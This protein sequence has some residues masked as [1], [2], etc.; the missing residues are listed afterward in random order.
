MEK[1]EKS[2]R[3]V[4]C[5]GEDTDMI[6]ACLRESA[7]AQHLDIAD[8]LERDAL[9]TMLGRYGN[10]TEERKTNIRNRVLRCKG[11]QNDY[12]A[13]LDRKAE[14]ALESGASGIAEYAELVRGYDILKLAGLL[15]KLKK[16]E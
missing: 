5:L 12:L 14:N 1:W 7:L 3:K 10:T 6:L 9:T 15:N 2:M 4:R 13:Y 8:D 11:C 16:P